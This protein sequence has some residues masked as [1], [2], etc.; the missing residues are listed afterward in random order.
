MG[1][2]TKFNDGRDMDYLLGKYERACSQLNDNEKAKQEQLERLLRDAQGYEAKPDSITSI[3][4]CKQELEALKKVG[5]LAVSSKPANKDLIL[6]VGRAIKTYTTKL[7]A[8]EAEARGYQ[9]DFS[10]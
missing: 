10:S 6:I 7:D 2:T 9:Q 3:S 4:V 8:L 1:S 5:Q